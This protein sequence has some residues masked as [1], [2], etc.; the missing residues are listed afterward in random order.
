ML[1]FL[2]GFPTQTQRQYF[3]VPLSNHNPPQYIGEYIIW[4]ALSLLAVPIARIETGGPQGE[5]ISVSETVGQLLCY[6]V[7]KLINQYINQSINNFDFHIYR[8]T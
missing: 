2:I 6:S 3:L 5:A 8:S 1:C 4:S 7:N